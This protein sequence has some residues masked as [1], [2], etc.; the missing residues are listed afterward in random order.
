M[1]GAVIGAKSSL[2]VP[3]AG[4]RWV[5]FAALICFAYDQ[6]PDSE[7]MWKK[8]ISR[9]QKDASTGEAHPPREIAAAILLL[10]CARADFDRS[11]AEID[12]V[13][14]ALSR[15]FGLSVDELKRIIGDAETAAEQA[16]SLHGPISRL[17]DTL[18][19]PEKRALMHC[20]W[21]VAY[22]DQN[23]DPQEEH[24]LRQIADLMHIPHA[25]YIQT[26]LEVC[27]AA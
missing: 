10:E 21:Q 7:A 23:I 20:L 2:R 12:A 15:E 19:G 3:C 17:N 25:D 16:V 6:N 8:W 4:P 27:R 13:R 1:G 14:A 22:A 26:K 18:S 9:L 11:V 24:L 5:W